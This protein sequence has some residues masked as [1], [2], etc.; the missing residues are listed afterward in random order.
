MEDIERLAPG[1]LL[2]Q[3]IDR[4]ELRLNVRVNDCPSTPVN[5]CI[6]RLKINHEPATAD[7]TYYALDVKIGIRESLNEDLQVAN[8]ELIDTNG[9]NV[10]QIQNIQD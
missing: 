4:K 6:Y 3:H 7:G 1:S 9:K 8:Y 10:R 5:T 2:L